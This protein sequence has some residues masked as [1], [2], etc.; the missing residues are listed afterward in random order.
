MGFNVPASDYDRA[1]DWENKNMKGFLAFKRMHE[2][3]YCKSP[4]IEPRHPVFDSAPRLC[5]KWWD[6]EY[7]L[8]N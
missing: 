2:N 6:R 8:A 5:K 3:Y 1:I 4:D 7:I